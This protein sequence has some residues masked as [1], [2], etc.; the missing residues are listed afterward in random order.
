MPCMHPG[1]GHGMGVRVT[2]RGARSGRGVAPEAD[3]AKDSRS[4]AE[5]GVVAV[6]SRMVSTVGGLAA[7]TSTHGGAS[8]GCTGPPDLAMA[9]TA[10]PCRGSGGGGSASRG[11]QSTGGRDRSRCGVPTHEPIGNGVPDRC[12]VAMGLTGRRRKAG[13]DRCTVETVGERDRMRGDA[14]VSAWA[15]CD[16]PGLGG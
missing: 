14:C 3:E 12:G 15:A 11:E 13:R 4:P 9:S 8:E 7:A 1:H 16:S 5:T 2:G 6:P 10:R